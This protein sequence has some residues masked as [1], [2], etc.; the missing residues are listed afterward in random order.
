M[1]GD[2]FRRQTALAETWAAEHGLELDH[3]SYQ[4]LGVSAFRGYN[5]ETGMLGEFLDAVRSG[6]VP[7]GSY[8][9]IESLDRLSRNKPRKAIRLLERICEEGITLVTLADGKTYTEDLL[10]RD[11]MAFM[12]AFMVAIRANEE[13]ETKSRRLKAAWDNKRQQ[14]TEKPVTS[15]CPAWLRL[16]RETQQFEVIEERAAIVARVFKMTLDGI[17]QHSIADTF[18]KEGIPPFG[19]ALY[20]HRSYIA[21]ILANPAVIGVMVPHVVDYSQGKMR[22]K[23]LQPVAGYFPAIVSEDDYQSVQAMRSGT[24][25]AKNRKSTAPVNL[26]AGLVR[27]P[28]CAGSMTRV[29]KGSGKK[30]GT[31]YYVCA[32]AKAGAGCTYKSVKVDMV[33]S[34]LLNTTDWWTVDVPFVENDAGT[35][36]EQIDAAIEAIDTAIRNTVELLTTGP[37]VALRDRLRELEDEKERLEEEWGAVTAE[38]QAASSRLLETRL[39]ELREVL[40][41]D[42]IDRTRG[43]SLMKQLLTSVTI[44]YEG[45]TLLL[46]WK[47]SAVSEV[48]YTM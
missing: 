36:I 44:D 1:Q 8:L 11:P 47:N 27:C 3:S 46:E 41:A 15:K 30:A 16:N 33:E 19:R 12:W 4:D 40:Q 9:L 5:A 20:W 29:S 22:R 35:R 17:G 7:R 37:S 13:S 28:Q 38:L 25:A 48:V 31:P 34:A 2:S 6:A 26:L 39:A 43:N 45:G 10:D 24:T 18:N 23:P 42:E 14:A 32:K 21:K